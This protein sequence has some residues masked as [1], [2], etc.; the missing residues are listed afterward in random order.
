MSRHTASRR[1]MNAEVTRKAILAAARA[2]FA[3]EGFA[4]TSLVKIAEAAQATTGAIYH[5]FRDKKGLFRAVAEDVERELLERVGA[6]AFS[7][8]D[9]WAQVR[10]GAVAS[11]ELS[12]A[13]Q[14]ARIIFHE[15]PTVIGA[16]E[17]RKI[18]R[19]YAFGVMVQ[20]LNGLKEA[21][22][23]RIGNAELTA[24]ILLGALI[25]AATTISMAE[26][27]EAML[28]QAREILLHMIEVL[29]G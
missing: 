14:V 19:R 18:E 20:M 13:P 23:T 27:K 11:L 25:E 29:R 28:A 5:H 22:A 9:P 21:G 1:D 2:S 10:A 7:E 26:D 17:W 16:V 6:V 12:S 4:A 15:A 24:S 8:S 3:R